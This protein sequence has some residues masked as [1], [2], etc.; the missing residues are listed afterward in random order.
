MSP[1]Y[2]QSRSMEEFEDAFSGLYLHLL[3]PTRFLSI[4]FGTATLM[5]EHDR[6]GPVFQSGLIFEWEKIAGEWYLTGEIHE[7]LD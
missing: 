6:Y 4:R 7:A 2:R 1:G 3:Y 5:P